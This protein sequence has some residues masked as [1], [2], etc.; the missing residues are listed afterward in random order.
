[1][2]TPGLFP[3]EKIVMS[4]Q[5]QHIVRSRLYFLKEGIMEVRE[6][7]HTVYAK[8]D[9][10]AEHNVYMRQRK[11]FSDARIVLVDYIRLVTYKERDEAIY[12]N[13]DITDRVKETINAE[14]GP[15]HQHEDWA[16]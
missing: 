4:D 16:T 3:V 5:P 14:R 13:R 12:G 15:R 11:N 1:M 7:E 8:S 2:A 10:H 9:V 6:F